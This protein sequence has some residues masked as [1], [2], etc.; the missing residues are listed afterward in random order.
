MDLLTFELL[1]GIGTGIV[2]FGVT[3]EGLEILI[4]VIEKRAAR[5]WIKKEASPRWLFALV[6]IVRFTR[7]IKLWVEGV[8]LGIVISG[9]AI[10]YLGTHGADREQSRQNAVLNHEAQEFRLKADTLENEMDEIS[11]NVQTGFANLDPSNQPIGSIEANITFLAIGTNVLDPSFLRHNQNGFD[12]PLA[13]I[14]IELEFLDIADPKAPWLYGKHFPLTLLCDN[15]S[16]LSGTINGL[17]GISFKMHFGLAPS[18]IPFVDDSFNGPKQWRKFTLG[19][20]QQY[21]GLCV[22]LPCLANHGARW[23]DAVGLRCRAAVNKNE[24]DG[25]RRVSNLML[26][27]PTPFQNAK[28]RPKVFAFRSRD[29]IG[30]S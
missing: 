16:P 11:T 13:L 4:K 1:A 24:L 27:Q 28:P 25:R 21:D 2:V 3:L 15:V 19:Q 29:Q 10:E 7:P 30:F 18:A 20:F 6:W 23:I 14:G 5:K 22:D 17:P 26:C 9:L 8:G 12:S